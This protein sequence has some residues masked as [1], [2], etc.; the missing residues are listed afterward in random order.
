MRLLLLGTFRRDASVRYEEYARSF[1][2]CETS[3]R[4]VEVGRH[5]IECSHV[6]ALRRC[7]F[8]VLHGKFLR[9]NSRRISLSHQYVHPHR[10]FLAF[11]LPLSLD[12]DED[13]GTV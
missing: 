8:V 2:H 9:C 6:V 1:E 7:T 13:E 5:C 4:W 12:A 3:Q 11:L 10:K